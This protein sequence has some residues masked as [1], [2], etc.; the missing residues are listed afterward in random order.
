MEVSGSSRKVERDC[1]PRQTNGSY[2]HVDYSSFNASLSA[3]WTVAF[4]RNPLADGN[5]IDEGQTS[6]SWQQF[7]MRTSCGCT[8]SVSTTRR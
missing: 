6:R 3:A 4:G 8:A 2:A 5:S 7:S 1:P